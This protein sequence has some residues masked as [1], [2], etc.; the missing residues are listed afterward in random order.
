MKA[1]LGRSPLAVASG[2]T[3]DNVCEYL[4]HADC[5]LVATGIS[6][7]FHDLDPRRVARLVAEVRAN[8]GQ[9]RRLTRLSYGRTSKLGE[10]R[11]GHRVVM[12]LDTWGPE[13][14]VDTDCFSEPEPVFAY[15]DDAGSSIDRLVGLEEA[16]SMD[17]RRPPYMWLGETRR[18]RLLR[19]TRRTDDNMVSFRSRSVGEFC[20]EIYHIPQDAA[21]RLLW[22][23]DF[24]LK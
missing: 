19:T 11:G 21:P 20:L 6:Q 23:D 10:T 7:S 2:I 9:S 24:C 13:F 17:L 1:A 15:C 8:D 16:G 4:P 3:P 12:T 22:R 14:E 5:F 18:C